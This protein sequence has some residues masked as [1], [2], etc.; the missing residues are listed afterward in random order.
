M[1][2]GFVDL[3]AGWSSALGP[4]VEADVGLHPAAGME[5]YG[6]GR[7]DRSGWQAGVAGRW[8]F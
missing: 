6:Y 2:G 1:R 8:T 7:G 3:S 4:H 5:L